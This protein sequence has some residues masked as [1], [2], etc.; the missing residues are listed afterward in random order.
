MFV[1]ALNSYTVV[2]YL[3]VK[4]QNYSTDISSSALQRVK[5]VH[6]DKNPFSIVFQS[7]KATIEEEANFSK[8]L[9]SLLNDNHYH[10]ESLNNNIEQNTA[11]LLASY[12]AMRQRPFK[13]ESIPGL[14][15]NITV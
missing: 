9:F 6:T 7:L 10:Y 15:V 8:E 4:K 13:V 1:Q 11:G 12:I 5:T 2:P 14:A 3:P